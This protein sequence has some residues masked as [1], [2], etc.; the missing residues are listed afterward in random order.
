MRYTLWNTFP[1]PSAPPWFIFSGSVSFLVRGTTL[2]LYD[3]AQVARRRRRTTMKRRRRRVE[4]T[5]CTVKG[6][7][8]MYQE[9]TA[10]AFLT[11]H[12]LSSSYTQSSQAGHNI[13]EANLCH[14]LW[15]VLSRPVEYWTPRLSVWHSTDIK[16]NIYSSVN[17]GFML[18]VW[19]RMFILNAN[20]NWRGTG[21]GMK[22]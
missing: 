22:G 5:G 21:V 19:L 11:G 17:C 8:G 13:L 4:K 6:R 10:L 15:A 14:S 16:K 12:S 7:S 2:S 18:W 1:G 3:I 9:E 20:K